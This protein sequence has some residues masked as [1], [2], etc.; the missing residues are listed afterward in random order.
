MLGKANEAV[1]SGL[2][3]E[4]FALSFCIVLLK[5]NHFGITFHK[6]CSKS[7]AVLSLEGL[8]CHLHIIFVLYCLSI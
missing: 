4:S 7:Y 2:P 1:A 8:F 5:F 3:F 6:L